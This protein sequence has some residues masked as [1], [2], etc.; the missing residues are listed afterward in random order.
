[1]NTSETVLMNASPALLIPGVGDTGES[2]F[3]RRHWLQAIVYRIIEERRKLDRA[4]TGSNSAHLARMHNV[5]R[6]SRIA[7]TCQLSSLLVPHSF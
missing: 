5:L 1:M 6:S 7:L 3:P 4:P 2:T